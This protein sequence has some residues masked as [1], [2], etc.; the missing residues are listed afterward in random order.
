MRLIKTDKVFKLSHH[1]FIVYSIE[2]VYNSSCIENTP[3]GSGLYCFTRKD[4]IKVSITEVNDRH[5]FLH[6]HSLLYLGMFKDFQSRFTHHNKIEELVENGVNTIGLLFLNTDDD[7]LKSVESEI[8]S[9]YSFRLNEK[10]N[11]NDNDLPS[12]ISEA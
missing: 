5:E 10:E 11:T 12:T 6:I 7:A 1:T 3:H 9:Q 8:L 2:D 4:D